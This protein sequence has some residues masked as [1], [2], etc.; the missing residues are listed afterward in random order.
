[1]GE[2]PVAVA[3]STVIFGLRPHDGRLALHLPLVR[4]VREPHLDRW[5]LPGGPLLAEE[6]LREAARRTLQQ[7]TG[8]SPEHLEQLYT[9]GAVDRGSGA[10]GPRVVSIVYWALV[11]AD[12]AAL[13]R[14]G[15][16]VGWFAV[17]A[18]PPLAFDHDEIVGWAV[19]RLVA[20]LEYTHISHALLPDEFTLGQ[21]REV[22][23]AILGRPLDPANFRRRVEASG[24]VAPTG[25]HQAGVRHRPPALYRSTAKKEL[26]T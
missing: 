1:M 6:S 5:A 2:Q 8:L 23:E 22:H 7:T 21:L 3:V 16:N 12:E 4:R 10:A 19:K 15:D 17:E 24:T 14:T 26:L 25:A 18:L 20:K 11:R 13:A 9:F